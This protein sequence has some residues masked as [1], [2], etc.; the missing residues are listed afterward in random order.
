MKKKILILTVSL[1]FIA[2]NLYAAG[3][4]IV[5]GK[6]GVGVTPVGNAKMEIRSTEETLALSILQTRDTTGPVWG[7]S[8]YIFLDGI[9]GTYAD[10][11][12]GSANSIVYR[13]QTDSD[14]SSL[15]YAGANAAYIGTA[16]G[17]GYTVDNMAALLVQNGMHAGFN[18]T[19][20]LTNGY[21]I[22]SRGLQ[23]Y[24]AGGTLT[25]SNF[26]HIY[27]QDKGIQ[28]GNSTL[29]VTNQSGIWI[30][31][32]EMGNTIN[33]GIV[34]NGDG[35]GADIVFGDSQQASI[36]STGGLLYATDMN[37]NITQF[38]PHDP[39][40]GEWIYYSKNIKTGKTVRVNMEKLVEAVEK[41][42]GETF[43]IESVESIK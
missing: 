39:E 14:S 34:L 2:V 7:S 41:L 16:G 20:T 15:L 17:S 38:S 12:G 35:A 18:S 21:G 43:M 40:T 4:L 33:Y 24:G 32:Q 13:R 37:G 28:G 23:K 27:L 10:E 36:Y 8:Y 6:L 9:S 42:T 26:R 25:V 5:N 1:L 22:L 19:V 11:A 29:N 30:D 3:D 31:K